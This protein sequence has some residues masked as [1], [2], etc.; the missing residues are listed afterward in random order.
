MTVVRN[1]PIFMLLAGL[2]VAVFLE[3]MVSSVVGANVAGILRR[4]ALHF[5]NFSADFTATDSISRAHV[6]SFAALALLT[7][8]FYAPHPP[9]NCR[10]EY[11]A[12]HY[13]AKA[14]EML[15]KASAPETIFTDDEWGDYLIYRLYPGKKVFIDGRSDFYGPKFNQKYLDVMNVRYDWESNLNRYH[16]DTILLP[17][18]SPLAATLKES[19]HW[20]PIYDDGVAIV[21]RAGALGGRNQVSVVSSDGKYRDHRIAKPQPGDRTITISNL[22]SEPS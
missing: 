3:S 6:T 16:V 9:A 19:R 4:T 8:L 1:E 5:R 13:P 7:A 10:A 18:N 14:V 21:F 20:H 2:P 15:Q 17:P 11:D 12:R 22:R